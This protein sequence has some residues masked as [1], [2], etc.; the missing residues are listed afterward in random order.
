VLPEYQ[1]RGIGE[2]LIRRGLERLR[3]MGEPG[4]IVVGHAGYYPRFGFSTAMAEGIEHPF[5]P[6][7]FMAMELAPGALHGVRGRVRYPA[8][9]GI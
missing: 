4:V 3:E 5:P 6:D 9:F 7:V 1:R 8:E 2:A